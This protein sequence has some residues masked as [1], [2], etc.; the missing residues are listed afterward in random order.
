MSGTDKHA[1]E[2]GPFRLDV[3]EG[4]LSSAGEIIP[5]TP[6]AF[7]VLLALVSDAGN[8]LPKQALM[9][10][11]WPDSFVEENNLADNISTLR[12][13]L[14]DDARAPKYIETV[15]RRGYRF[16]A[17]VK[18]VTGEG[19]ALLL[20]EHVR[21]R[22]VIEEQGW[23][24]ATDADTQL[25][26]NA[27]A[28]HLPAPHL[29]GG[30]GVRS[31]SRPKVAAAAGALVFGLALAAYFWTGR[32]KSSGAQPMRSIAVLP[33]KPLVR[34]A[35]DPSLELGMTDA[36]ITRLSNVRQ[37]AVRPTSAILK[38][39]G[40]GQDPRAA[41]SELG[42]DVVLDGNV[43]KTGDRIRLSVQLVRAADGASVW[44]ESFDGEFRD[45][46]AVQDSIAE[47]VASA[48]ALRLTGE[49]RRG[50]GRRY[51]D[52]PEAYQ[53]YMRGR[54]LLYKGTPEGLQKSVENCRQAAALD[55]RFAAAYAC[56]ADAYALLGTTFGATVEPSAAMQE[57]KEAATRALELE[58]DSCEAHTSLAWIRYRFDWDWSGAEEEFA[59]AVALNPGDAQ[60]HHWRA[61]YLT[62]MGRF[63]EALAEIRRARELDPF[64]V[65][66][67]WNVGRI[68][69]FARRYDEALGELRKTL[70]MD[71][72]F[73]RAHTFLEYIY[74]LKGMDAEAFAE[75]LRVD[76]LG[77]TAPERLASLKSAYAGSGLQSVDRME[78]EW[79]LAE[80]RVRHVPAF[81]LASLFQ[82][83]GDRERAL[84]W[85][86]KALDERDGTVVYLKVDPRWDGFRDDPRF[87]RLLHRL[88]IK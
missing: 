29:S 62:A 67:N 58:P 61:D 60:V 30:R 31:R 76:A 21:S 26:V 15:P 32:G 50:L 40:A 79:A 5:L 6:K 46:F 45:V 53:A 11:V 48:L 72:D 42:V 59:R 39:A 52:N 74:R 2:F 7:E 71:N 87:L 86:G 69:Y 43:Q 1:Y 10:K 44:A 13:V 3:A 82:R 51:T 19:G 77:G 66:I 68:L 81:T 64:S 35:G 18:E 14:G 85:L 55:P 49:D 23:Q 84:E 65:L 57:A 88:N 78:L 80:A 75:H 34:E 25:S 36:L 28:A 4:R 63:D 47:R 17:A 20:A 41:G 9:Q 24:R 16:V 37:I 54:Y 56:V 27:G 22:I 38:Y 12:K 73:G 70:D 8:L 83:V 33:F